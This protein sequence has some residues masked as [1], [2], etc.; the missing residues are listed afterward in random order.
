MTKRI[1]NRQ[2][3]LG[4]TLADVTPTQLAKLRALERYDLSFVADLLVKEK[5]SCSSAA[6]SAVLEFKRYMGLAAIGYRGLPVPSQQVDNVWHAFLMFTQE[7]ALFCRKAVGFFVHHVPGAPGRKPL[8]SERT[9]QVYKR[10]F[11]SE[12]PE[13][14]GDCVT[15][16][17]SSKTAVIR[18]SS[19]AS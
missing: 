11:G 18:G 7:Y 2:L 3:P 10:V 8:N 19:Y 16:R 1:D 9:L 5:G 17:A 15:C 14:S 4:I 12:L 13:V 6:A